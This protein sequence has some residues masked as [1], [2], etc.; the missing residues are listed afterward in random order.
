LTVEYRRHDLFMIPSDDIIYPRVHMVDDYGLLVTLGEGPFFTYR[1]SPEI[2]KPYLYPVHGPSGAEVTRNGHPTDPDGHKHHRSIWLG[3]PDVN[4]VNFW[5]E[6]DSQAGQIFHL[7]FTG[8]EEAPG[9]VRIVAENHWLSTQTGLLLEETRELLIPPGTSRLRI[10]DL[11][12][13]LRGGQ[14][15]VTFGQ[16]PYGLL[17]CR[18]APTMAVRAGGRIVNAQGDENEV[19]AL[20]K[21]SPW[22]EYGGEARPGDGETVG[23]VD[24]EENPRFPTAWHCR[25]DGWFGPAFTR[26]APF[27]LRPGETLSLHYLFVFRSAE[28]DETEVQP[29]TEAVNEIAALVSG[30]F[31]E[32]ILPEE[33]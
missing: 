1:Y 15:E 13:T 17:G 9:V 8:L 20:G 25:D 18:V 27:T 23:I 5:E 7:K 26:E 6:N 11:R 24:D 10:L 29:L 3:H 30:T 2:P 19:G 31:G 33:P 12:T 16:T 22:M 28:V 21:R 32:E 14:R 4:G